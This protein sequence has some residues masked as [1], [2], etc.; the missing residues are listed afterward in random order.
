M[1]RARWAIHVGTTAAIECMMK[2]IMVLKYVPERIDLDPLINMDFGQEK[3]SGDDVMTFGYSATLNS[4]D[5]S[6]IAEPFNKS[7]WDDIFYEQ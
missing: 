6:L 4:I 7:T 2:G 3:V 1:A 5:E